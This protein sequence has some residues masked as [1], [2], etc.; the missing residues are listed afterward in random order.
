MT[1][2]AR[3]PDRL[4]HLVLCRPCHDRAGPRRGGQDQRSR[5]DRSTGRRAPCSRRTVTG[6]SDCWIMTPSGQPCCS[7][8]WDRPSPT[9]T[10]SPE[11]QLEVMCDLLPVAWRSPGPEDE[12]L[13][14][15]AASLHRLVS[16]LAVRPDCSDARPRH[17]PGAGLR[18]TPVRSVRS[19]R[20]VVVHGDPAP[21]NTLRTR[22]PWRGAPG[23]Y[24]FVDPDGFVGDPTYDLG[25]VLRG[26]GEHVLAGRQRARAE[27][28]VI[29]RQAAGWGSWNVFAGLRWSFGRTTWPDESACAQSGSSP[30]HPVQK[31]IMGM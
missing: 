4:W 8:P 5:P 17:R 11:P 30:H 26:W 16:R 9:A 1:S 23:G 3:H 27:A 2:A 6:T 19:G 13:Y 7:K 18:R 22:A 28:A 20:C 29:A 10:R 14:D 24:V 15:K 21:Q 31:R 12:P 25:V